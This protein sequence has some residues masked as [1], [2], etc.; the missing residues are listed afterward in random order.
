MKLTE[1]DIMYISAGSRV[2]LPLCTHY[3]KKN[4]H[5]FTNGLLTHKSFRTQQIGAVLEAALLFL[6]NQKS[7]RPAL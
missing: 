7:I 2:V 1:F 3:L 6:R 4:T 5:T